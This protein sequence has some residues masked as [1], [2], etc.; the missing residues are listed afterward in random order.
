VRLDRGNHRGQAFGGRRGVVALVVAIELR[1]PRD[2]SPS[3]LNQS[4]IHSP[5]TLQ[6]L[7]VG[8]ACLSASIL[9]DRLFAA[10]IVCGC[11]RHGQSENR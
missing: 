8:I 5:L 9:R 11:A 2:G 4:F 10:V 7:I 1:P 3:E 6:I